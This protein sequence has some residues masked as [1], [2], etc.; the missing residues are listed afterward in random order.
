MTV[1]WQ[2][3]VGRSFYLSGKV[4]TEATV[5]NG[6]Q[7]GASTKSYESGAKMS[8]ANCRAGLLHGKTT[9]FYESGSKRAEAEYKDG[10]CMASA[11]TGL[12]ERKNFRSLYS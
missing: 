1:C 8:E 9:S 2:Q 10:C 11:V 5:R 7:E 3:D 4:R 6:L 12:I